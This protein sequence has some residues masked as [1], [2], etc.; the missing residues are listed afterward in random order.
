MSKNKYINNKMILLKPM[1]LLKN[2]VGLY[3][4]VDIT[5]WKHSSSMSTIE[6]LL[7]K[8]PIKY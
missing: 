6:F 3:T 2:N 8:L 7:T 4:N 1:A 5:N